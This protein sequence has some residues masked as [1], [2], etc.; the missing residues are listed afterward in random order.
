MRRAREGEGGLGVWGRGCLREGL[1]EMNFVGGEH[2]RKRM[3]S[4]K[5]RSPRVQRR[6]ELAG[7][8]PRT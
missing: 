5:A 2:S 3:A 4:L 1:K 6:A 7:E 8:T